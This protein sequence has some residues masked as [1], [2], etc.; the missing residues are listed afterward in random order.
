MRPY[1]RG[2][3]GFTAS[4]TQSTSRRPSSGCRCFGVADFIRVPR[5]AAITTA[6][7]SLKAGA[8]GFEPGIAGP[9]PAA[10][11]LGYAPSLGR[12]SP[13]VEVIRLLS[14]RRPQRQA[15]PALTAGAASGASAL[16]YAPSLG[17]VSPIVEVI[18]L[19]S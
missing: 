14:G 11:P 18:R 19:L 16:G 15:A 1:A 6:A 12:V 5:P 4:T 10:L 3:G 17:R 7:K 9:K 13:I 8:P 2:S